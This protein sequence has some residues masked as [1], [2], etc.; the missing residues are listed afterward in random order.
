V[1][2]SDILCREV[3]SPHVS[4]NVRLMLMDQIVAFKKLLDQQYHLYLAGI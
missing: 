2:G 3:T 1:K 4:S